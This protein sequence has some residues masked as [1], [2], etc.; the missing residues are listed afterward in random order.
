MKVVY[1]D[2]QDYQQISAQSPTKI[3]LW[4]FLD[5]L[6]IIEPSCDSMRRALGFKVSSQQYHHLLFIS[7]RIEICHDH[8]LSMN[9]I[10]IRTMINHGHGIYYSNLWIV[11]ASQMLDWHELDTIDADD[12]LD[13]NM[14]VKVY[15]TYQHVI[16]ELIKRPDRS[17]SETIIDRRQ[18]DIP[19]TLANRQMMRQRLLSEGRNG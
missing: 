15:L 3:K 9:T 6:L 17:L 2:S 12:C 5:Q 11:T 14:V 7:R 4:L 8:A 16:R 1:Y 18:L 19:V 13:T 10:N